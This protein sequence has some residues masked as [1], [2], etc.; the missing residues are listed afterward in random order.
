[1]DQADGPLVE[2]DLDHPAEEPGPGAHADQA[3]EGNGVAGVGRRLVVGP[4]AAPQF[5]QGPDRA[6]APDDHVGVVDGPP[7]IA[8]ASQDRGSQRLDRSGAAG[9]QPDVRQPTDH[10]QVGLAPLELV[11]GGADHQL[12]RTAQTLADPVGQEPV[13]R[14]HVGSQ[15]GR[16]PQRRTAKTGGHAALPVVGPIHTHGDDTAS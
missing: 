8:V 9:G 12:D 5:L 16:E 14:H 3:V 2:A 15:V 7:A 10:P 1:V 6:V 11:E 4:R 13:H